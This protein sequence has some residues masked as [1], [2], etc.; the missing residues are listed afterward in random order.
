LHKTGFADS[1]LAV[2]DSIQYEFDGSIM[3]VE[4]VSSADI[5]MFGQIL[6]FAFN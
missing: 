3:E 6:G 4:I 1:N 5:D 2:V